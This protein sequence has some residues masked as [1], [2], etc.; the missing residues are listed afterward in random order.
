MTVKPSAT[1]LVTTAP[2]PTLTLFP[3]LIPG[4]MLLAVPRLHELPIVTLPKMLA[5]GEI[6]QKFPITAS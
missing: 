2:A 4:K 5:R 1:S 3:I 6:S